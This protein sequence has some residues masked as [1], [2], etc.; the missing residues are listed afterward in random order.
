M[1]YLQ[2]HLD[3]RLAQYSTSGKN[4]FYEYLNMF[5]ISQRNSNIS[6]VLSNT[7]KY[8]CL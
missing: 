7:E 3:S 6:S 8:F 2:T 4:E 1:L 5:R